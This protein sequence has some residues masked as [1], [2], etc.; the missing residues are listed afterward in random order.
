MPNHPA[1]TTAVLVTVPPSP[2]AIEVV[3]KIV[4]VVI[5]GNCASETVENTVIVG[6]GFVTVTGGLLVEA[7]N[8]VVVVEGV[9]V[10]VVVVG[11][12]VRVRVLVLMLVIVIVAVDAAVGN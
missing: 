3:L 8:V 4:S 2:S 7:V 12:G 1:V 6:A 9:R 11:E 10:V 5:E